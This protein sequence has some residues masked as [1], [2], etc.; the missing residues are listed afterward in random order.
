MVGML[1]LFLWAQ[2]KNGMRSIDFTL[3]DLNGKEISLSDYRGKVVLL[4]F[5]ASW[6]GPCRIENKNVVEAYHKYKKAKF[7]DAKGFVILS[8]SLDKSENP[9]KKGIQEDQLVWKSHVW[10]QNSE[11]SKKY[12]VRSIPYGFLIDSDGKIIAQGKELRGIGLHIEIEKL[13]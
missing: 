6:C 3:S 11:V 9:W 4:D 5:W 10:D 2:P 1:P 8:V 12:G 13:F 7:K